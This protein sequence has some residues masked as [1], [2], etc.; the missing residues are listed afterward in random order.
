M[1]DFLKEGRIKQLTDELKIKEA[2]IAE[3][4]AQ[5]EELFLIKNEANAKEEAH[6]KALNNL[7]NTIDLQKTYLRDLAE[8][9]E[10]DRN[11]YQTEFKKLKDTIDEK[12]KKILELG[13]N[14]DIQSS[15]QLSTQPNVPSSATSSTQP[16]HTLI[17]LPN[18]SAIIKQITV[19]DP[20]TG[21]HA[22]P[23]DAVLTME[24]GARAY[25]TD[26][27]PGYL[28][29]NGHW[30][31]ITQHIKFVPMQEASIYTRLQKETHDG[32]ISLTGS[33]QAMM[34]NDSFDAIYVDGI[35]LFARRKVVNTNALV[36]PDKD[37]V[38]TANK[39]PGTSIKNI[40]DKY[41]NFYI[42]ATGNLQNVQSDSSFMDQITIEHTYI[43]KCFFSD[44]E[45]DPVSSW[46]LFSA[47]PGQSYIYQNNSYPTENTRGRKIHI[48]DEQKSAIEKKGK[49]YIPD[50]VK[51]D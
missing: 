12:D 26:V 37:I 21:F 10:Y 31:K 27:Y 44:V 41:C 51:I 7:Q 49:L 16:N 39:Y 42:P 25:I 4:E 38:A 17:S 18:Q 34:I 15:V 6:K 2:R 30:Y 11:L 24:Y 35:R 28:W 8:H 46:D 36:C 20:R 1:T 13:R 19:I 50:I 33:T 14:V 32:P 48:T 22:L 3:L 29:R 23:N 43:T 45:T 5:L 9:T 40:S 47:G